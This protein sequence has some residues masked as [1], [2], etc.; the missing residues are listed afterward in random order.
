MKLSNR[1]CR[2]Q[3]A[4]VLSSGHALNL[5]YGSV[6]VSRRVDDLGYIK[7]IA[8]TADVAAFIVFW[9]DALGCSLGL[10]GQQVECTN[11]L[12]GSI[13]STYLSSNS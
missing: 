5:T 11:N 9:L 2:R 4:K 1:P 6:Q 7:V 3:L 8:V 10:H 13:C 12:L